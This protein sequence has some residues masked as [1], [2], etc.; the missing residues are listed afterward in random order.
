MGNLQSVRNLKIALAFIVLALSFF[1]CNNKEVYDSF[2]TMQGANWSKNTILVFTVDSTLI[3]PGVP[4]D[5]SV[6]LVTNTQYPYQNIWFYV[7]DDIEKA[8]SFRK[9]EKQFLVCDEFGK[10]YGAGFGN[11]HQLSLPFS[12]NV[13][14]KEKRNHI[15]KVVHG[16]RDEPLSGVEKIGL[17]ITKQ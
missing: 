11:L 5:V 10:W 14:F 7:S 2:H 3:E 6:E 1:S 4:C 13:V 17:K 9:T 8:G 16:M 15:F 12:Q